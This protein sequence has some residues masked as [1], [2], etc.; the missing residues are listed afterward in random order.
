MEYTEILDQLRKKIVHPVYFLCGEEPYYIDIISDY[1]EENV[2]T[3]A[4]K[5]FNLLVYYGKDTDLITVLEAARRYPMN[6]S[7][8]VIIVKEAQSWKN[9]E[10]LV[11]YLAVPSKTT[12]LVINY[13]Y[14]KL[15]KRTG[16]AKTILEKT[17]FLETARLRDNQVPKWIEN[18]VITK[19][20]LITPQAT[21]LLADFLGADLGKIANEVNKLSLA[22]PQGKKITPDDIEKNI[23]ISK[24]YNTFELTDALAEKNVLKANRIAYYFG[25]DPNPRISQ[26]I[27]GAVFNFFSKLFKYHFLSDKND[28]SVAD[29][30]E[31]HPFFVRNYAAAAKNYSKTKIF[32]IIG[33][34]REYD[35]KN[36]GLESTSGVSHGDLLKEMVYKILH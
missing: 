28:K 12:I 3:Q 2:L 5:G 6:A 36:K 34:I 24:E 35:M 10:H 18:H 30:L 23:G 9:L 21:Q 31:I 11:R 13:K 26:A 1:I 14:S 8:Q 32:E 25:T 16:T 7:Q 33:I 22:V 20:H 19:G 4:E 27:S 15:D 17:I 29:A